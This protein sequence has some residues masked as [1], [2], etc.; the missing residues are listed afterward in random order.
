MNTSHEVK[1]THATE[2]K[3]GDTMGFVY[4]TGSRTYL[5]LLIVLYLVL[6]FVNPEVADKVLVH[7]GNLFAVVWG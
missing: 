6:C 2:S 4:H 3:K 5:M 7:L 1:G